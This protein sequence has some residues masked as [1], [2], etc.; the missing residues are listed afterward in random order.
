MLSEIEEAIAARIKEKLAAAAGYVAVQRGT[1]GIPQPAVYV[2]LEEG[3]F[4]KVSSDSFRQT[5]KGYVDIVFSHLGNE[6]QRRRGIY[7]ILEGIV[8]TLLLQTLGLGIA[9]LRPKAFRNV[10]SEALRAKGLLVYSLEFET[11][12][13]LRKLDEEAAADLLRVGLNYYLQDPEDDE[14]ADAADLIGEPAP[15]PEP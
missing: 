3:A 6:E 4:E 15:E 7:P 12:C 2:S 14:V 13:H 10:T 1:E 11:G 5:V 9:P 8:Q